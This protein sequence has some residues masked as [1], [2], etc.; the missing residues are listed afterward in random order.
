MPTTLATQK[1]PA[2]AALPSSSRLARTTPAA[3]RREVSA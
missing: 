2:I 1:A 3:S